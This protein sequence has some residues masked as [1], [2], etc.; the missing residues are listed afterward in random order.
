MRDKN[1]GLDHVCLELRVFGAT[2]AMALDLE[3]DK[4]AYNRMLVKGLFRSGVKTALEE[5]AK[6]GIVSNSDAEIMHTTYWK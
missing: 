6:R 4:P 5:L 2:Y 1:L 3:E